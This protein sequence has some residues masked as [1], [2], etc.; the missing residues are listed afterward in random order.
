MQLKTTKLLMNALTWVVLAIILVYAFLWRG[1][2]LKYAAVLVL[3]V[4]I[5]I[6]WKFWRCPFCDRGLQKQ[7]IEK[8]KQLRCPYCQKLVDPENIISWS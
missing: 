5:C 3:F 1:D 2:V 8:G 4:Q 7:K 6:T